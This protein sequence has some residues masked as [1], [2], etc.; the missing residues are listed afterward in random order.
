MG[1]K[2]PD[3]TH[4]A[5]PGAR[6]DVHVTPRASD[7]R[8]TAC[9]GVLRIRVTAAPEGGK[10]NAAAQTLLAGALGVPKSRLVLRRG[11]AGRDKLFVIS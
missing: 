2:P 6:I 1:M 3:L 10:A 5:R 8:I 4:L 9:D 11:R 7:N